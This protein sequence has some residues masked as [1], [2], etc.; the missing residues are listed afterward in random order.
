MIETTEIIKIKILNQT[1]KQYL[2]KVSSNN[3]L[4]QY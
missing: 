1:N 2:K 3:K 4:S